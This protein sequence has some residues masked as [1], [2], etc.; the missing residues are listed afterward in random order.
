M[1]ALSQEEL[2][3]GNNAKDD[4]IA[5]IYSLILP[6]YG[7]PEPSEHDRQNICFPLARVVNA[8]VQLHHCMRPD[9]NTIYS[10]AVTPK[11]CPYDNAFVRIFS[12]EHWDWLFNPRNRS[13]YTKAD[14]DK[15]LDEAKISRVHKY[16]F[17]SRVVVFEPLEAYQKGGWRENNLNLGLRRKL[18]TKGAVACR[19]GATRKLHGAS[20]ELLGFPAATPASGLPRAAWRNVVFVRGRRAPR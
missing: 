11:D 3:D 16:G 9:G 20:V 6:L 1:E 14:V 5:Q 10:W 7:K 19:W 13:A 18:I 4:L 2:P 8:A 15:G 12:E 17:L